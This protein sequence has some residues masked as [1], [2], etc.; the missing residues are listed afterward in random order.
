MPIVSEIHFIFYVDS[1]K[2]VG[3]VDNKVLYP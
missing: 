3:G 1:L 2:T